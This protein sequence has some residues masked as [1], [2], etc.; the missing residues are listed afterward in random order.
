MVDC[1]VDRVEQTGTAAGDDSTVA[2]RAR[3][4]NLAQRVALSLRS[5]PMQHL[6]MFLVE[7]I[8]PTVMLTPRGDSSS[9]RYHDLQAE[10]NSVRT[11]M[12]LP[13]NL[14]LVVDLRHCQYFRSEFIGAL[15]S[16]L[17]DVRSR[18]GQCALC[19]ATDQMRV[20]LQK[21]SLFKLWPYFETRDGALAALAQPAA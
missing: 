5:F 17:R 16:M 2:W 20:V 13:E 11:Y 15:V 18:Q 19:G 12:A 9:Y 3:R 21:M 6:T 8:G 1:R 4:W 7:Q 10:V 14:N